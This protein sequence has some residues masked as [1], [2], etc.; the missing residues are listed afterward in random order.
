MIVRVNLLDE[1]D[2]NA[3]GM[4]C[5]SS[6]M[7]SDFLSDNPTASLADFDRRVL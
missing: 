3:S 5:A 6:T 7:T 1:S 4:L 2:R